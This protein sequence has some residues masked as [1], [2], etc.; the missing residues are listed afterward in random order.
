LAKNAA[1]QQRKKAWS[2]KKLRFIVLA[3]IPFGV[4]RDKWMLICVLNNESKPQLA[5]FFKRPWFP[6]VGKPIRSRKLVKIIN[7]QW[8]GKQ[9]LTDP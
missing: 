8:G 6:S 1:L 2:Q 3:H 5:L 4:N 9:F 7:G